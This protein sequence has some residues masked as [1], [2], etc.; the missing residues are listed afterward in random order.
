MSRLVSRFATFFHDGVRVQAMCLTIGLV[1]L[2]GIVRGQD[3][4]KVQISFVP[5]PLENATYSV[6][7][8]D[9]KSGRLVRRLQEGAAERAFTVGLNGLITSWDGKDDEGKAVAPGRYAARGYAVGPLKV[10][11]ETVHGND[12]AAT[13]AAFRPIF[14]NAIG[15]AP[16]DDGLIVS[17]QVP[18]H[19]KVARFA[20]ADGHLV[21]QRILPTSGDMEDHPGPPVPSAQSTL[22]I[23]NGDVLIGVGGPPHIAVSLADAN[24][25]SKRAPE[26]GLSSERLRGV[27]VPGKDGTTWK[28]EAGQ[29]SQ[30]SSTGEV[31]R[32]LAPGE[33]EPRCE[34]VAA[35]VTSDKLYILERLP[36]ANWERVRGLSWVESK[37]ENGQRISTWQ[38][39]F[40]RNIGPPDVALGLGSPLTVNLRSAEIEIPL[41]EN[42]L[43]P[44]K[45]ARVKLMAVCGDGVGSYLATSDGLRLRQIGQGSALIAVKLA[46]AKIV[47]NLAL[48]QSD[49]AAWDEFSIAGAQ[50]MMEF[51]AGEFE[52]TADGERTHAEKPAEPPDL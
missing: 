26:T 11:G 50:N 48:F 39:F 29:L 16:E 33:G 31:L 43:A 14:I 2:A 3:S 18:Y 32:H 40:E 49:W 27:A 13:D 5:P 7:V 47:N 4:R 42:P 24:S 44:G 10:E 41:V 34:K 38:T 25:P 52:M 17:A 36:S 15:C 22:A 19:V 45:H 23:F 51:D 6:G 12:W 20:G 1:A 8:Y 46:K 37:E 30:T 21:W 28:I 35:S 9:A